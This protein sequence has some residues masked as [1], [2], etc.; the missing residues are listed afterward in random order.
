VAAFS[1]FTF[2][3]S[4]IK[5]GCILF[6]AHHHKN[7]QDLELSV[8]IVAHTSKVRKTT[9]L[10]LLS[11]DLKEKQRNKQEGKKTSIERKIGRKE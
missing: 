9:T 5:R 4:D 10:V 1:C 3:R 2:H 8:A 6:E 11:T 7:F